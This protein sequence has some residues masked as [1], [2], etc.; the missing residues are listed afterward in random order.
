L[1]L[2]AA[3]LQEFCAFKPK[4]AFCPVNACSTPTDTVKPAPVGVEL[5][6]APVLAVLEL[7]GDPPVPVAL[8]ELPELQPATAIEAVAATVQAASHWRFFSIIALVPPSHCCPALWRERLFYTSRRSTRTEALAFTSARS[9][10]LPEIVDKRTRGLLTKTAPLR[11]THPRARAIGGQL[12]WLVSAP[13]AERPNRA[14]PNWAA[15]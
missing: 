12:R 5:P 6:V 1:T 11:A 13:A 15:N 2:S 7:P 9:S 14:D 4:N 8:L 10:D 3:A